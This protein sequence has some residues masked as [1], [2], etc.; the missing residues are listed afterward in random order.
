MNTLRS[1]VK[2]SPRNIMLSSCWLL[3]HV[4]LTWS[5]ERCVQRSCRLAHLQDTKGRA[6]FDSNSRHSRVQRNL[7]SV[8]SL[9]RE[10]SWNF[11]IQR[12]PKKTVKRTRGGISSSVCLLQVQENWIWADFLIHSDW[13]VSPQNEGFFPTNFAWHSKILRSWSQF[14]WYDHPLICF[15]LFFGDDTA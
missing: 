1:N 2:I 8:L 4:Q 13:A 10:E 11:Q 5:M 9:Y 15:F 12:R 6:A 7:A 3:T 14:F